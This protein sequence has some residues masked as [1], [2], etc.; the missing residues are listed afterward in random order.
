MKI[1]IN[2]VFLLVAPVPVS[3]LTPSVLNCVFIASRC[4]G[5]KYQ[6]FRAS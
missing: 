6:I 3:F 1:E 4:E 2:M 5:A